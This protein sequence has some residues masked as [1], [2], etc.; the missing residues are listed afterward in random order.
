MEEERRKSGTPHISS[1]NPSN[2]PSHF[3]WLYPLS[4]LLASK[5]QPGLLGLASLI[6]GST[7]PHTLTHSLSLT[8]T[9]THTLILLHSLPLPLP[10]PLP[11]SL[12]HTHSCTNTLNHLPTALNEPRGGKLE[13]ILTN[14]TLSQKCST[15]DA[16]THSIPVR[17][18]QEG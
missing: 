5:G 13:N 14:T 3:P 8:H 2:G 12:T 9:H 15:S 10:L 17:Q 1:K 7:L 16:A 11:L 6:S 4:T 18:K